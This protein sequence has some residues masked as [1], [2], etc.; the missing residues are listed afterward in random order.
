MVCSASACVPTL[1]PCSNEVTKANSALCNG[2]LRS[3]N[4]CPSTLSHICRLSQLSSGPSFRRQCRSRSKCPLVTFQLFRRKELRCSSEFQVMPYFGIQ[5]NF[6]RISHAFASAENGT[7][8]STSP[9]LRDDQES[10]LTH[11]ARPFASRTEELWLSSFMIGKHPFASILF[12]VNVALA[13]PRSLFG[14][15]N[16]GAT[17]VRC[18]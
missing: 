9:I 10:N 2:S 8:M 17:R 14:S 13:L 7:W 3:R 15:L 16:D 12:S 5:P 6:S 11:I 4:S 1:N 18:A